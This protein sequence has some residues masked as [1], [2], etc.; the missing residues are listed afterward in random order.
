MKGVDIIYDTI[1]DLKNNKRI[2]E[3]TEIIIIGLSN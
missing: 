2:K 3:N 1:S